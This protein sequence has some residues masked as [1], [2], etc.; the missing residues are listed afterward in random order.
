MELDVKRAARVYGSSRAVYFQDGQYFAGDGTPVSFEEAANPDPE[1]VAA[2]I[3]KTE[4]TP[5]EPAPVVET[6]KAP[7]KVEEMVAV[8]DKPVEA[9]PNREPTFETRINQ[10]KAMN[11]THLAKMVLKAGGTPATGYGSKHKNI[12]WLLENVG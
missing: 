1:D 9:S 3:V 11:S 6:I 7:P 8:V 5:I 2:G 12:N 4:A 10:L